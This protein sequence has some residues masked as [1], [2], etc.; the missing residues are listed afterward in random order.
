MRSILTR[1]SHYV[2]VASVIAFGLMSQLVK[3]RGPRRCR[4]LSSR[5]LISPTT[6]AVR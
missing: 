5:K 1:M 3:R 6:L 2:A 4:R